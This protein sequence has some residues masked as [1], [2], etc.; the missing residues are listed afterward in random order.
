MINMYGFLVDIRNN[1]DGSITI[2]GPF[3]TVTLPMGEIAQQYF[4]DL[5]YD[6]V[7]ADSNGLDERR[8]QQKF[9]H[10]RC[11]CGCGKKFN[12]CGMWID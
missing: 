10:S 2:D 7:N 1:D 3:R 5:A 4:D 8:T 9:R 12:K 6:L 11:P